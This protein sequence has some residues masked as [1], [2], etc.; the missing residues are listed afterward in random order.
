V[1]TMFFSASRIYKNA[2]DEDNDKLIHKVGLAQLVRFLVVE[3]IHP[4]SN[5]RFDMGVA[6]T[7]NYS[8]SW[9]RRP[10]DSETLLVTHFMNL[11]I[12]LTQSFEGAHKGRVCVH[13]FIGVS[14]RTCMSIYVCTVFLK[15]DKLIQLLH[16]HLVHEV[17]KI[18]GGIS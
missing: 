3:L 8:F 16:K 2:V 10:V 6:F 15:N 7:A 1:L 14:A 9:R 11:K 17:H 12:K 5:P 13:V 18:G 4:G